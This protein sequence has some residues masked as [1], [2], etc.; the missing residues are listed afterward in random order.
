MEAVPLQP[1]DRAI[2]DL[3]CETIA[4]HTCKVIRLGAGAPGVEALRA[5]IA[6]RLPAV[7]ELSRRLDCSEGEAS[8]VPARVDLG[9]H[10]RAPELDGPLGEGDL[11]GAVARLFEQRLDRGRPLWRMDVAPMADGGAVLIWRIHHALADGTACTRFARELLWD[12]DSGEQDRSGPEY[13][14]RSATLPAEHPD[15]SRRRHHLAAFIEREFGE[16]VR[17]SPFDGVIGTRRTVALASVEMTPLHDAAK[18]IAGAT[19][20]DA[21][22]SAV[23]GALRRWIEHHHGSLG[24]VR[25]RVPVSLHHE[26]DEVANRD[27]FFSLRLPLH[28]PEPVA[29][30]RAVH[31]ATAARKGEHDAERLEE[32]SRSLAGASPRMAAFAGRIEAS[33][34]N[35]ALSVSNVPGPREP[36][37]LLGAPVETLHSLA[38][39]GARHALRVAVVSFAGNLD[40]GFCADPA[41]VPDLDAMSVG[42]EDEAAALVAARSSQ[43]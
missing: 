20:N 35:F 13:R 42:V 17:H 3:E 26:G 37:S 9:E 31:R 16:S 22:L 24:D 39:I 14:H 36:V 8:W 11:A 10:V 1:A 6:Q 2:L 4:G 30:L 19:L 40:F 25:V 28:E 32:L 23:A 27:S 29:R 15:H 5:R 34:R 43:R 18:E 21:V 41:L 12:A 33:P 7:P 38:E